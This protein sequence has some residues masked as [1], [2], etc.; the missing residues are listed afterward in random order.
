[1][2]EMFL[3]LKARQILNMMI[4]PPEELGTRLYRCDQIFVLD[5]LK[6]MLEVKE[7][8]GL[9]VIDRK[10]ATIGLLEGK[11]I[12]ILQKLESGV[13]G[14]SKKGGQSAARYRRVIEGKAKDFFF[15]RIYA[16]AIQC[17]NANLLALGP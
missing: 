4:E 3:K 7:L 15:E 14:K 9:F 11:K 6:E 16:L 10:E 8:Y 1:M 12:K 5:P 2:L 17:R 13:P